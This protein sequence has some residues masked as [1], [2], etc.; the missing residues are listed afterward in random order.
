[1]TTALAPIL[2]PHGH[3]VLAPVDGA[4]VLPADLSR[5]LEGFFARGSGHGLLQLGAAEVET[6][7]PPVLAYWREFGARYVTAVCARPHIDG[8]EQTSISPL[9]IEELETVA[10]SAP[11]M[12]GAQYLTSSVLQT[13]W[14]AIDAAFRSEL[15]ES[16]APVQDFLKRKSPAWNLVGRVHFNLAVFTLTMST[17]RRQLGWGLDSLPGLV[18]ECAGWRN[19]CLR[20]G[21]PAGRKPE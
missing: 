11:P 9:P 21:C 1:M 14:D 12:T 17:T 4:P 16:N 15:A 6:A 2:T 3:L 19:P 10:S 18:V 7:L 5:R 20:P 13:L 8:G